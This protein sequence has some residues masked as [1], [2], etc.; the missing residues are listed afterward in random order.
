[1][2]AAEAPGGSGAG[3]SSFAVSSE[4]SIASMR[5][6][7]SARERRLASARRADEVY[8]ARGRRGV[9][10][11]ERRACVRACVRMRSESG[12]QTRQQRPPRRVT[13]QEKSSKPPPWPRDERKESKKKMAE[14]ERMK[15][16]PFAAHVASSCV[17]AREFR[18]S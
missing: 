2:A 4:E 5:D 9:A 17:A 13:T 16:A 6:R 1:M 7:S 8:A 18:V 3:A 12:R 11:L 15:D 14:R 10:R